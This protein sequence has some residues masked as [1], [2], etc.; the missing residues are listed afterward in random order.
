M[1]PTDLRYIAEQWGV[2]VQEAER[3]IEDDMARE[4]EAELQLF[5][6]GLI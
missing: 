4:H 1:N 6:R 3:I 5:M 2:S